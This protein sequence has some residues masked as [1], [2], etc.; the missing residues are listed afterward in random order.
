MECCSIAAPSFRYNVIL[1]V[2]EMSGISII[3]T[4]GLVQENISHWVSFSDSC[5]VCL[6]QEIVISQIS[7]D[8]C[9][10]F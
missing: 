8:P 6:G 5:C 4:A 9:H 3:S 1:A 7:V 2:L 10:I